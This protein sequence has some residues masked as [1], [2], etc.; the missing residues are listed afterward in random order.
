MDNLELRM[1]A[2]L[3]RRH[4]N[5]AIRK[6][7]QVNNC[8][9]FTSNDYLSFS[10]NVELQQQ[11]DENYK[12]YLRANPN[13]A[14]TGSRL[15]TGNNQLYENLENELCL[16]YNSTAALIFNSGYDA[17][18]SLL[19]ACARKTDIILYDQ[20]IHAS[21]LDGSRY[22]G[23]TCV[24]FQHNDNHHLELLLLQYQ[25]KSTVFVL[26]ESVYSMDGDTC[27]LSEVVELCTKYNANLIVDEA[28]C[29]GVL[30]KSLAQNLNLT[31]KIWARIHT[32]GKAFGT[33][34]AVVL[35]NN[36]LKQYLLNYARPLI[37]TTALP[38]H[39]LLSIQCA[40]RFFE[41][42]NLL[43]VNLLV[44]IAYFKKVMLP[45]QRFISQNNTAI[46]FFKCN[47]NKLAVEAAYFLQEK[48]IDVR[49]I[50]YPTVAYGQER[51]RICLHLHNSNEDIL[52]LKKYLELFIANKNK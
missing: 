8:I 39:N 2:L 24:A 38:I 40:H 52:L 14:A 6:L 31:N 37:Y 43:L 13:A 18:L 7:K 22:S 17:N 3:N 26:V 42:N 51:L 21:L 30:G 48:G 49:P 33:N 5:G 50:L 35:G 20:L 16:F 25:H 1:Q 28:H 19:T 47:N 12:N 41:K 46:Q 11:I 32:F 10:C 36:T 45:L 29:T 9:D 4:S 27:N 15:L 23:A 44:K 34:G